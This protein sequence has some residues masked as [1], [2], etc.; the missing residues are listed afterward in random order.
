M[1]PP[2]PP[3]P[4]AR[5]LPFQLEAGS[6]TSIPMSESEVGLMVAVMRQ[7]DGRPGNL[8][9]PPLGV[10]VPASTGCARTIETDGDASLESAWHDSAWRVTGAKVATT[11]MQSINSLAMVALGT[12][13]DSSEYK[14]LGRLG[15]IRLRNWVCLAVFSIQ[16][17]AHG[18]PSSLVH[19]A[20]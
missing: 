14:A 5:N 12:I 15:G 16:E 1:E 9:V 11:K 20:G 17:I 13:E 4:T 3:L 6:Q 2:H 8:S 19:F 10:K 7:N 18:M